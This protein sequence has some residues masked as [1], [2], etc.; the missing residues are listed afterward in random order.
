MHVA[1]PTRCACRLLEAQRI[2]AITPT[3]E[4]WIEEAP[5]SA[6]EVEQFEWRLAE[7]RHVLTDEGH[8]YGSGQ[9]V[10]SALT[11]EWTFRAY[12]TVCL[13]FRNGEPV[14]ED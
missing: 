2:L 9:F 1:Q 7:R 11:G 3:L 6:E 4:Q 10:R 8:T 13:Q 14:E 5:R 12:C